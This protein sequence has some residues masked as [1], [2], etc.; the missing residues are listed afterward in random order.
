MFI[1]LFALFLQLG[2]MN[3]QSSSNI[4]FFMPVLTALFPLVGKGIIWDNQGKSYLKWLIVGSI[5]FSMLVPPTYFIKSFIPIVRKDPYSVA[6]ETVSGPD[7]DI[8]LFVRNYSSSVGVAIP[9]GIIGTE[10][11]LMGLHYERNVMPLKETVDTDEATA[12]LSSKEGVL[13]LVEN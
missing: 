3:F 4:R 2:T 8:P 13:N 5:L 12:L 10:F 1:S 9:G 6:L 11:L 7:R